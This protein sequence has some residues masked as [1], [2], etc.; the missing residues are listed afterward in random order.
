M[1]RPLEYRSSSSPF[2]TRK[3][4]PDLGT[5]VDQGRPGRVSGVSPVGYMVQKAPVRAR[6][7][8][9]RPVQVHNG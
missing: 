4:R 9:H 1:T 5:R 7:Q 3:E 2:F 8:L 6:L